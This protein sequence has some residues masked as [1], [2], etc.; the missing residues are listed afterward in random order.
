MDERGANIDLVF[1]N[2]L[3][4]YEVLPPQEV[5]NSIH[6][7]IKIKQRPFILLRTAAMIAVVLT[8]SF[9]AYKL[10]REISTVP[11]SQE[12]AFEIDSSSPVI[13]PSVTTHSYIPGKEEILKNSSQKTF[14]A[15]ITENPIPSE[16][17][18]ASF[19]DAIEIRETNNILFD[20]SVTLN[21]PILPNL[22]SANKKTIEVTPV[23]PKYIPE[24]SMTKPTERWSIGAMASPTYY[25]SFNSDK[26]ELSNQLAASEQSLISYSGGVSLSYKLNKRF[27]IQTG[28]YYSSL[29]Q[30]IDGISSFG[31]FQKYDYTKGDHNFEVLTTS[32]T[33]YTNNADV[34]LIASGPG[35]RILTVYTNDVF[36]PKKANLQYI[37]NTLIQNFSFIELPVV[38]RYK[39]IDKAIDINL[40]GGLS[41]NMMVDNS[42]YTTG[43][44]VKYV[45][46]KTEGLNMLTVSSS[47]GLGMEYSF[48][49]KLSLNLEP[50]FR[51]YLNP[52]N[53]FVGSTTH[54]YSFG[55]FSGISYRF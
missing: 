6:P 51:Y 25:S 11:V 48:S 45:I 18:S 37:N 31:G 40:L 4:D 34:F 23:I 35:E 42:V 29:G 14:I 1:R 41:Y 44:G 30:E 32:G 17:K 27:S 20:R 19:P 12:I 22:T 26:S 50:T 3:K 47:F 49:K 55:V 8:I 7:A 53:E 39:V 21:E 13:A 15:G 33:V 9:L 24:S 38:L 43:D 28:L 2:G 52:F 10:S 5:W 54:P 36:D 16:I 46:G